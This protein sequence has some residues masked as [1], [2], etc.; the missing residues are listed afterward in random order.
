MDSF[1]KNTDSNKVLILGNGFDLDLG[2]NTRFS[3]YIKSAYWPK[4]KH[5]GSILSYLES[6][7]NL[8]NWFDLE[9]E[10]GR[11][12]SGLGTRKDSKITKGINRDYFL[13]LADGF[14]HYL[15]EVTKAPLIS[16][17][18]AAKV[19]SAVLDNSDFL[20]IYS[21]NYTSLHDIAA[22]LGLHGHF[23]YEHVHGSLKDNS[24]IIGAPEDVEL[25]PGYEFLYKTFHEHYGS[26][27]L[28]HD[29][30]DAKEVV[31]FGHSLGPTDYHYSQ[32]FFKDQCAEG[33]SRQAAKKITIFTYDNDSRLAI[34]KQLRQ[35]NEKR[36]NLLYNQND[37]K[38]IMTCKGDC[39]ELQEFLKHLCHTKK[40]S[41]MI[42]N[43]FA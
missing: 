19:L 41:S 33:L 36:T 2:W 30:H 16:D 29:L 37:F 28:I 4:N 24:L 38:I 26:N 17:S 20:S 18:V 9:F 23:R 15:S 27:S 12:F 1:I 22:N 32:K 14:A 31:F 25:N 3:D 21:F 34:L 6:R 43:I 42:T 10:I 40:H 8:V 39:P 5:P 11:Y 13:Q 7:I 35:M